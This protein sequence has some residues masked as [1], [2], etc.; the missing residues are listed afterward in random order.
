MSAYLRHVLIGRSDGAVR[1][2]RVE[3]GSV[4][5]AVSNICF[6][7][8]FLKD[9]QREVLKELLRVKVGPLER[10]FTVAPRDK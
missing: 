3:T 1:V 8:H 10:V 9:L 6:Y 5:V 4:H 7:Q 2:S